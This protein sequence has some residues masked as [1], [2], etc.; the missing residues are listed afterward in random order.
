[1]KRTIYILSALALAAVGCQESRTHYSDAE[2]VMFADT[3]R[4]EMIGEQ[5]QTFT[6]PV[7]S[8]VACDYDR[9]FGV[10]II[11]SKSKAIEGLHYRLESNTVTIKAGER[12]GNLTVKA[13]Y[14]QLE[15]ADT[16][17]IALKLVMPEAVK[18]DMYGDQTNVK[19]VKSCSWT[20]EDFTGW[21]VVTS[22]FVYYYPGFNTSMQ[23]LIYTEKHPTEEN[24]IILHNFLYDGY[25]VTIRLDGEDPAHPDITMDDDQV[26]SDEHSVFGTQH[27]DNH[28]L[29]G[30]NPILKS[31][32]NACQSFATLYFTVYVEDM[33]E[34]IGYVTDPSDPQTCTN[35]MEWISDEE[36]DYLDR[37]GLP[38]HW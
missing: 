21:C 36:A 24:T 18:W 16:L 7:A 13:N 4:V 30:S 34:L 35:I 5:S 27:G 26:L 8:T 3:M 22:T 9:N 25:D 6:V 23:R 32:F 28:I 33:G 1:M 31:F 11:D 19:M 37:D 14:D 20:I 29:V 38:K 12:V 15:P 17:N 2:Y 10:E